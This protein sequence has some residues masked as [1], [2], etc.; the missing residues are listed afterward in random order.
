MKIKKFNVGWFALILGSVGVALASLSLFPTLSWILAYLL[1]AIFAVLTIIWIAKIIL[2][3]DI[4][5]KELQHFM[6]GNFYP[7]QPISAVLLAI[8]Y[9]KL[10]IPFEK[11][12]LIYGA[13][14]IFIL[15][16]YLSYHF[17]AT[18]TSKLHHI[19]G[20]WFI[21]AVSTIL[22]TY[23]ILLIYPSNLTAFA[24]SLMFFGIGFM[25]FLF[26]ATILFLRLIT[27]ELPEAELAP[28]NFL[29][30]APVGIL[31][32]DFML[33]GQY[34]SGL[35]NAN[36]LNI[37]ALIASLSLWG[38]GIWVLIINIMILLK[39]L[40]KEYPFFLGWWSYVFPTSAFTVGTMMLSH[41]IEML[42]YVAIALY[43]LLIFFWV[44]VTVHTFRM[45]LKKIFRRV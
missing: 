23:A 25:L 12:L 11:P 36:I 44:I 40:G 35:F 2:H 10:S 4:V 34:A 28:T 27:H 21:P 13:V 45:L 16:I 3:F 29:L 39:Y 41:K 30:L 19:H 6:M 43:V 7:L 42:K 32:L 24:V 22:V 15:A 14:L 20:G 9:Y 37:I 17:F 26:I 5:S 38:F 8:L 18:T 33:I 1:T 31:I